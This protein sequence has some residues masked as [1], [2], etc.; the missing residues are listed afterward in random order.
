MTRRRWIADR[1][2]GN[3][4]YLTGQNASH[5][6]RV[7]RARPGQQ[8]DISADG[9]VRTGAIVSISPDQVEFELGEALPADSVPDVVVLLAI[10]KFDRMEWAMEK[11]TELGVAKMIPVIARRSET[12]LAAAAEKRVERWR[13]IVREA[14]QQSRRLAPPVIEAPLALKKAVQETAGSRLVLSEMEDELS[15]KPALAKCSPP[16]TLAIGPEGGWTSEELELFQASGWISASLGNTILRA[17]TA[18]IA[19]TAIVMSE[20]SN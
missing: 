12:H 17:E 3:R 16:I 20:L 10:F 13:K 8:F 2:T 19:A 5:L 4:A 7:L 9:E 11:L 15:L 18:A 1:V 14:A 6:A